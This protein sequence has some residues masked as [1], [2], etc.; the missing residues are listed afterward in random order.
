MEQDL[1]SLTDTVI[2]QVFFD[3]QISDSDRVEIQKW[4][5]EQLRRERAGWKTK[6][7]EATRAAENERKM[8][9]GVHVTIQ[10]IDRMLAERLPAGCLQIGSVY[11]EAEGNADL[12]AHRLGV[13]E[14][15]L[16]GLVEW[17]ERMQRERIECLE[18]LGLESDEGMESLLEAVLGRVG[19]AEEEVQRMVS[20]LEGAKA[21]VRSLKAKNKE[22]LES[23]ESMEKEMEELRVLLAKWVTDEDHAVPAEE[24]QEHEKVQVEMSDRAIQV[25]WPKRHCCIQVSLDLPVS[26]SSQRTTF[27]II[28]SERSRSPPVRLPEVAYAMAEVAATPPRNDHKT[29]RLEVGSLVGVTSPTGTRRLGN[30]GRDEETVSYREILQLPA[31]QLRNRMEP[32]VLL[33]NQMQTFA[34]RLDQAKLEMDKC[35]RE[36]ARIK[37]VAIATVVNGKT[38]NEVLGLQGVLKRRDHHHHCNHQRG[39]QAQRPPNAATKSMS[40]IHFPPVATGLSF[41]QSKVFED[42]RTDDS[43]PDLRTGRSLPFEIIPEKNRWYRRRDR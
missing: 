12:K 18:A 31:G 35:Q 33:Q 28:S 2:E 21:Q 10:R 25:E 22:F 34:S 19:E 40:T 5:T 43:L 14:K 9:L 29:A 7:R 6:L 24:N 27:P 41:T 39:N 4:L 8:A 36:L 30:E 32:A 37:A 38:T 16:E 13:V 11:T 3:K 15:K 42:K 17:V 1:A 20:K 23:R 26:G